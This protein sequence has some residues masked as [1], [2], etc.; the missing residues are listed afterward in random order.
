ML[1]PVILTSKNQRKET[2][3]WVKAVPKE[4]LEKNISVS[5]QDHEFVEFLLRKALEEVQSEEKPS[6]LVENQVGQI[7]IT[8]DTMLCMGE[9]KERVR[10]MNLSNN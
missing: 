8:L 4:N 5:S 10:M 1:I 6:L 2:K 7:E 3:I 9:N